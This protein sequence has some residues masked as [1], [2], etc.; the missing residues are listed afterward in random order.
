MS[1]TFLR[2]ICR[3]LRGVYA[4]YASATALMGDSRI[5]YSEI[6]HR[7]DTSPI[8]IDMY[9]KLLAGIDS[10]VRHSYQGAGFGD[11][12]RPGP[13]KELLVN[14]RIHPVLVNAVSTIFQTVLPP[15]KNEVDRMAIYLGDYTW[16]GFG[17]DP[18][19]EMYRRTRDMDILKKIPLRAVV[20]S[21]SSSSSSS[22][23]AAAAE[24]RPSIG[25]AGPTGGK[26]AGTSSD[27]QRRRR[28]IRCC[29]VS[30]DTHPPRS[31]LS[32]QMI[33]RLGLLRSCICGGMW[34]L[35]SSAGSNPGHVGAGSSAAAATAATSATSPGHGSM[36]HDLAR[37]P[38]LM[39]GS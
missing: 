1:R 39:Q 18:R 9:E 6:C 12:E 36:H 5:Y 23:S 22:S 38:G 32:F 27:G 35:E 2:F 8:R 20:P 17:D 15:L 28:C 29:E 25:T 34:A 10:A 13:E 19:T 24:T 21:S 37:T 14:A 31:L 4:G 16:L 7:L 26:P 3:G 30:G 33:A 11:T